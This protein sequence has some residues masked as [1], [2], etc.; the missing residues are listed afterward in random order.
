MRCRRRSKRSGSWALHGW[1]EHVRVQLRMGLHSGEPKAGE[2]RYVGIGV[3]R[4]ARIGAAAHGGQVLVSEA[5][6]VLAEDD[7][8][9]GASL[10]DLGVHRLKDIDEPVRLHQVAAPGL[11]ERFRPPR[12]LPTSRSRRARLVLLIVALAIAGGS[13]AGV[14]LATGSASSKPARLMANSIVVHS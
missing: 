14:L 12:T 1:P 7:L 5:T 11:E 6:R 2:E 4:A 9:E 3:H 10:R 13:A 8:P